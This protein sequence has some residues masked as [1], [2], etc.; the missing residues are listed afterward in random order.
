MITKTDF[1]KLI[2]KELKETERSKSI[3]NTVMEKIKELPQDEIN[4]KKD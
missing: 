4:P 1:W 2:K 3:I